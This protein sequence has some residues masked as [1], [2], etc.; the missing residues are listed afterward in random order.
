M[1]KFYLFAN[2]VHY[3]YIGLHNTAKKVI[4]WPSTVYSFEQNICT[5]EAVFFSQPSVLRK[6]NCAVQF[7]HTASQ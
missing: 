3:K 5:L 1:T 6:S 2:I 7:T 4:C